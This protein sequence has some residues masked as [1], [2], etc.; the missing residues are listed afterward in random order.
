MP[1]AKC[2]KLLFSLCGMSIV[3]SGCVV[4]PDYSRPM[5][6]IPAAYKEE[7][8]QH[9]AV[10]DPA[11]LFPRGQWWTVFHQPRLNTLENELVISNQTIIAAN[12]QYRQARALVS[13]ARASY[14]PT[15]SISASSIRQSQGNFGGNGANGVVNFGNQNNNGNNNGGGGNGNIN[16][17]NQANLNASWEPDIWGSTHHSV[18][19]SME[20]AQ[21]SQ[22]TLAA[23]RLSAEASLAQYYFE[24]QGVDRDQQLLNK[25]VADNTKILQLTM[26][27]YHQG[28]ASLADVVQARSQLETSKAAAIDL[29]VNRGQYEHAIAVLIGK[30]PADLSIPFNPT[31]QVPPVIAPTLPSLL[32]QRRPDIAA[33]ERTVAQA[34][35]QIG[36]AVAAYYPSLTFSPSAGITSFTDWFS[37]PIYNWSI[38][39]LLTETLL[40]GGLRKATVKAAR[41]NYDATVAQY[42]QTILTAFQ[43]VEDNLVALRVLQSESVMK[44]SA[45]K[46]AA[47]S[48]QLT[49]NNFKAGTV[50]YPTV[51]TAQI[52]ALSAQKSAVDI[53]TLQM[54]STVGL[55]KALG[56]GWTQADLM[57]FR[58]KTK[59][60]IAISK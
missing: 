14:F 60:P 31:F 51:L 43:E 33:A 44:N 6:P 19:A 39:P 59:H 56:G 24:L 30:A 45:A 22:A 57:V 25:T 16:T 1:Y 12:A 7:S 5:I 38:G 54:T 55:I 2:N 11:D 58:N 8:K 18:E 26:N 47:L 29:E 27:R 42:R 40:D 35:A 53:N 32:L 21:S 52:N 34:N 37:S 17:V 23:T 49:V 4:G 48:L 10:A 3:L 13:E 15:L 20:A 36:V 46:D 9:W 50:N 41:A 28:V